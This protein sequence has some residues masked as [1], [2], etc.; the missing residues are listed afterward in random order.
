MNGQSIYRL[1]RSLGLT[2]KELAD[3]LKVSRVTINKWEHDKAFPRMKYISKL[4][5]MIKN[6][7]P[8]AVRPIQYLGSKL[9]LLSEIETLIE[10]HTKGNN[11][12][13]LFAGSGVVSH[14]LS[15]KYQITSLDIQEYSR[16]L[17]SSLVNSAFLKN[18][19]LNSICNKLS[20]PTEVKCFCDSSIALI[21]YEKNC[22]DLAADGDSSKLIEL[23]KHSSLYSQLSNPKQQEED[24][25]LYNL[26]QNFLDSPFTQELKITRLYGGVYFS[27]EQAIQ[28]DMIRTEIQK[29]P[30]NI[31]VKELLL[32]ALISA[33]SE[34][35]NTVGKQFA[36]PMKLIDRLGKPKKLLIDRTIRDRRYSLMD[37]FR[38]SLE[39][40]NGV[41]QNQS[42]HQHETLCMD[43][44]E[45]IQ[46]YKGKIDC[47]YIDP[48]YTID[49]YSRFYHVLETIAK[50]D[51][52]KL[53][54]MKKNGKECVM[55]GLYRIDRHQSPFCIPSKVHDSFDH[56][57]KY[58]SNFRAPII[59]SYSPFD[60]ENDERPRL[61]TTQEI[62]ELAS[63][64]Y[65]EVSVIK[66]KEHAHRKLHSTNKNSKKIENG[67]VFIVCSE[68]KI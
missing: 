44:M 22:I 16:V 17:T 32:A 36:Q 7:R 35:T 12:C 66:T 25:A 59:L 49:H 56:L 55:N 51:F 54:T 37:V 13:D 65:K 52:P 40:I 27:Y 50:Y 47:F 28:I 60:D 63:Q 4:E 33:S 68:A 34:I 5:K 20:K 61:M 38:K 26:K 48:P 9:R 30:W 39:R 6:K 11:I 31:D 19:M 24:V 62:T 42:T 58:C 57:F 67:E 46:T 45:F 64:Y 2:Q 10:K 18:E 21:S 53:A 23:S 29:G 43:S 1:R 8:E 14:F 41:K 3:K 15:S